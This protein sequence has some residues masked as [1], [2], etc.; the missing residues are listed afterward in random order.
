MFHETP[1]DPENGTVAL[2]HDLWNHFQY[3]HDI[4]LLCL[5]RRTRFWHGRSSLEKFSCDFMDHWFGPVSDLLT[6]IHCIS[7]SVARLPNACIRLHKA[8][9]NRPGHW[10][11]FRKLL[12]LLWSYKVRDIL[13]LYHL[14]QMCWVFRP[15]LS[16]YKQLSWVPK[17]QLLSVLYLPVH[18]LPSRDLS[19]NSAPLQWNLQGD[20]LWMRLYWFLDYG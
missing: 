8:R 17:S 5:V 13:P 11:A 6:T 4:N 12:F 16:I 18:A 3:G 9:G 7:G 1:S 10:P 19:W 20:W 2:D 15:P 14:W